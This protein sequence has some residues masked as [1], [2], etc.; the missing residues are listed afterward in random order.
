MQVIRSLWRMMPV[1]LL[2]GCAYS[3]RAPSEYRDA[4]QKA[5][6]TRQVALK[7]CY[8]GVAKSDAAASGRVTVKFT[9]EHDSGKIVKMQVDK[10]NTTAPP[11]V[12]SCVI[13][14]LKGLSITPPD[15]ADGDAT[16]VWDFQTIQ[17]PKIVVTG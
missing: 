10:D 2:A 16:F 8:D 7:G 9:V 11:A 1:A 5:L 14:S 12:S 6:D 13:E 17:P 4:T 15:K 3:S